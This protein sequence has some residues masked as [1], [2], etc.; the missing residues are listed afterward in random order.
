MASKHEVPEARRTEL[1]DGRTVAYIDIGDPDG[2]PVISN[3]GGLSCR[4]DVA[5]ADASAKA[6]GLRIL[7]PDRP[8]IGLSDPKPG[9][10][11]L[12]W[13][14]DVRELA[15][16][17][18][19]DRFSCIGWSF[20]GAFAQ[21][22]GCGVGDR[23][24]VLV[25]VASTIPSD[26]PGMKDEID[27]MDQVFYKLTKSKLGRF[28]ERS[29]LHLM[30][31]SA[32]HAPKAFGKSSGVDAQFASVV[33]GAIA[34]GTAHGKGVVAEY[35]AVNAPWG[36]DPS[37]ITVR[38]QIWQGDA[39]DLLPT[40]W[41]NRLHDAIEGSTMTIVPGASHFLWYDHWD[42]IFDGINTARGG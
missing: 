34:E 38:T 37:H 18:G 41:A 1:H 23:V 26:W 24:D 25:L 36:F 4:L 15:D 33:A 30:E 16:Q 39:D 31:A 6:H 9:H 5:P 14:D 22:V 12:G 11:V 40:D 13:G 10:T 20:G 28:T 17:L 21:V 7:A 27:H 19:I 35:E 3:H 42:D 32:K 8:G 2:Y 29:L